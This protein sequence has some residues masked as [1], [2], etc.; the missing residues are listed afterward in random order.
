[1][2]KRALIT[3]SLLT[4]AGLARAGILEDAREAARLLR[5]RTKKS[6]PAP[7][8]QPAVEAPERAGNPQAAPSA[9]GPMNETVYGKY[10]FVPGD[11]LIFYDDF[12]DTDVGEFPVKWHLKGPKDPGNNAVEV[13]EYQG[14]RFLRARPGGAEGNQPGATQYLRLAHQGDL[15]A[16]FTIEFDA[17]LGYA[18]TPDYPNRY[19]VYLLSNDEEWLVSEGVGVGVLAFS[20]TEGRSVNT[21]TSLAMLDGKMH[22]VAISVNGSFVKAYVDHQRVVN[23]PD[24]IV[25]PIR[26]VGLCLAAG[27]RIA[28]ERVMMTNFRLAEGG[29]DP[30]AAL[31]TDGRI[32][33]HGILFDTGSDRIKGESLPTLKLI[34]G[35]L[36]GDPKLRFSVEGHTDD[37]GGKAVNQPLS[38]RRAAAVM[39]WL[40]G[41]GI[42][43]DRLAAKGHGDGKP[44]DKNNSAE[45]RA[46][47]RRVEF[48]KF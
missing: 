28:N 7:A 16:R 22:H 1:M 33:S 13:V 11:K 37:Q 43:A 12:S 45:G 34:L 30:K 40:A 14:Q 36:Q 18:Q 26:R 8:P 21:Q 48:V 32:V 27:G 6:E 23:D 41:K 10:D 39:A 38:E 31:N 29:K 9:A 17:V 15:P 47:N 25:R 5:E 46:N 24:A 44:L 2:R 4:W 35:L 19:L 20:G 42:A 3:A